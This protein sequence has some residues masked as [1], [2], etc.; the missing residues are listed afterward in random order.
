MIR[1]MISSVSWKRLLQ[2]LLLCLLKGGPISYPGA[3]S[4]PILHF[5]MDGDPPGSL[6]AAPLIRKAFIF[7]VSSLASPCDSSLC[8]VLFLYLS[9]ESGYVCYS[10]VSLPFGFWYVL[11][12]LRRNVRSCNGKWVLVNVPSEVYQLYQD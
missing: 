8:L 12:E 4:T 5:S 11:V 2:Y 6:G 9:E 1:I 7:L 3:L 10:S